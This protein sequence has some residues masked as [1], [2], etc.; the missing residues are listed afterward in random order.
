MQTELKRRNIKVKWVGYS[1]KY[2]LSSLIKC[3]N[4]GNNYS[5][6]KTSKINH[7]WQCTRRIKKASN[8]PKSFKVP[9]RIAEKSISH[10]LENLK[11]LNINDMT[12]SEIKL[13]GMMDSLHDK[14]EVFP[15]SS[16]RRI[17]TKIYVLESNILQI[18]FKLGLIVKLNC[19]E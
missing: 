3:L 19:V 2:P 18:H 9:E 10:Y 6:T 17:V 1:G 8:Y 15:L 12:A 16:L 11:Q 5:R 4:C 14:S 13:L 7:V